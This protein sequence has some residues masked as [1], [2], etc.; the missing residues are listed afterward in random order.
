MIYVSGFSFS[1]VLYFFCFALFLAAI[2]VCS[3][4]SCSSSSFVLP[5]GS[6]IVLFYEFCSVYGSASFV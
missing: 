5:S 3:R 1:S 2:V 4:R 6:F